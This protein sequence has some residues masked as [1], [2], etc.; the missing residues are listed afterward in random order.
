MCKKKKDTSKNQKGKSMFIKIADTI[1][2]INEVLYIDIGSEKAWIHFK[3]QERPVCVS[4]KKA[5]FENLL[6]QLNK[7]CAD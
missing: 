3:T 5:D 2:N 1:I 6:A 4:G 7:V